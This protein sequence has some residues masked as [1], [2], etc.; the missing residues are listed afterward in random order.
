MRTSRETA[1]DGNQPIKSLPNRSTLSC[2]EVCAVSSQVHSRGFK[3]SGINVKKK[4]N[5]NKFSCLHMANFDRQS[6]FCDPKRLCN[7][8]SFEKLI[9]LIA[10]TSGLTYKRGERVNTA[11]YSQAAQALFMN[12][13][14][15]T[16]W[17]RIIRVCMGFST[18]YP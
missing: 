5:R 13:T 6:Y 12:H 3:V 8:L 17:R 10:V 1:K 16:I 4:L 11:L 15:N 14:R 18:R 9:A 2:S 7:K